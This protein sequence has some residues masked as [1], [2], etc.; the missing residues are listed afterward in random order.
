MNSDSNFCKS[1]KTG[2]SGHERSACAS[3]LRPAGTTLGLSSN[4]LQIQ[5]LSR[6]RVTAT[7]IPLNVSFLVQGAEMRVAE[8]RA[9]NA[10]QPQGHLRATTR[11]QLMQHLILLRMQ[12]W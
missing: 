7:P 6:I 5:G 9:V 4:R 12:P 1:M 2:Y 10:M 11:S 8:T 3:I